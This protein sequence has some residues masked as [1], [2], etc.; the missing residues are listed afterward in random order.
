M[1]FSSPSTVPSLQLH[2]FLFSREEEVKTHLKKHIEKVTQALLYRPTIYVRRNYTCSNN[3]YAM[4]QASQYTYRPWMYCIELYCTVLHHTAMH[5]NA[6]YC[7]ALC[8]IAMHCTLW[9]S[10]STLYCLLSKFMEAKG[11]GL[12]ML[13]YS[14]VLSKVIIGKPD[15]NSSS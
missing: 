2:L 10:F 5:G 13:L 1:P 9:T 15:L 11:G 12:S 3:T 7:F 14:V 6:L 8:C 4:H